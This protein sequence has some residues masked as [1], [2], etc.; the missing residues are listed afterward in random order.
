MKIPFSTVKYMHEEMKPEMLSAFARVYNSG[1]FI[2][3]DECSVFERAF[4]DYCG[5][6]DAV[7]C[8]N[9]LDAISLILRALEI[10]DGD[11][12]IVPEHTFIA[13]A[14]A[15]VYVGATPVFAPVSEA[16]FHIDENLVENYITPK[17]KGIIAV[18]LYGQTADMGTLNEISKKH[19]LYLIEDAAQAHGAL[20]NGKKT[21]SLGLAA[22]FSFYPGKNL[23]ALGDAG[24]VTTNNKDLADKV[25][26]YA[27][28]GSTQKYI[29]D[30][31]GINSRLDPMQAAFLRVKLK[32]LDQWTAERVKIANRYLKEIHNNKIQLPQTMN[33][34]THTW[35][36]FVIRTKY[37]N[38]LQKYLSNNEIGTIIHYPVPIHLQGAFARFSYKKN[39]FP[40]A[41]MLADEVLSLPLYIGMRDDE[42]DFV[43]DKL[44]Q[45]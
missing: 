36:L 12:V 31:Q 38:D 34:S 23:G 42:I 17:T 15:V 20:Y 22:A 18:H 45:F 16:S 26:A 3:G 2:G 4:A 39:D 8:G 29:H 41:E 1:W 10:G 24:M 25:R 14:L 43:I 21:G 35:H 7:G 37:R 30:Y 40:I 6:D 11:E 19:G 44:N 5:A 32:K 13:T 9:G 33:Y 28:Y 27:S